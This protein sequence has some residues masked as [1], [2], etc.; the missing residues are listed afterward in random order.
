M[1]RD[2]V[3]EMK[4][5]FRLQFKEAFA[6][7]DGHIKELVDRNGLICKE[8]EEL[9]V[10]M[11]KLVEAS[12]T[13]ESIIKLMKKSVADKN[14]EI[15][16][17][18]LT[19]GELRSE[20]ET[21]EQIMKIEIEKK[22]Q[23]LDKKDFELK[24]R[25]S[26]IAKLKEQNRKPESEKR[27]TDIIRALEANN[28]GLEREIAILRKPNQSDQMNKKENN[29]FEIS[30]LNNKIMNL[31]A[32][33]S[34]VNSS[35]FKLQQELSVQKILLEDTERDRDYFENMWKEINHEIGN[36]VQ[37][38]SLAPSGEVESEE[39]TGESVPRPGYNWPIV[40]WTPQS[41]TIHEQ[42]EE[43]VDKRVLFKYKGTDYGKKRKLSQE[44]LEG[45][46]VFKKVKHILDLCNKNIT[47]ECQ[48]SENDV[49]IID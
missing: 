27:L 22:N 36:F 6:E 17:L 49:L 45:E 29:D 21:N 4:E 46:N 40:S 31:I 30:K 3:D 19:V 8:N 37:T 12:F 9:R 1:E 43:Q 38:D 42:T 39:E 15:S 23:F 44:E 33:I 18:K 47:V 32:A 25:E 24:A 41:G 7:K 10:D 11:R 20:V 34:G 48:D 16:N 35:N 5:G 13:E 26:V 2:S 14:T 28:A